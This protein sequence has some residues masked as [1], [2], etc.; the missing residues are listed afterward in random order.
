MNPNAL[1]N[2]P[3]H[4]LQAHARLGKRNGSTAVQSDR[5][6][7]IGTGLAIASVVAVLLLSALS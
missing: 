2:V 7:A 6:W 4:L 5:A 3:S 1:L